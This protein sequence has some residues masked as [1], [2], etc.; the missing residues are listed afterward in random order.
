MDLQL[1]SGPQSQGWRRISAPGAVD[2]REI[3]GDFPP[4]GRLTELAQH[5]EQTRA[6]AHLDIAEAQGVVQLFWDGQLQLKLIF[7]PPV[8]VDV[9]QR[10]RIAIIIDDLGPSLT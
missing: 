5:I 2:T 1:I 10:S 6:P 3:F 9:A 4:P 8:P 7:E